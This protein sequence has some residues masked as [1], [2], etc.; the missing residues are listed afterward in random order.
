VTPGR[1]GETI[2][3]GVSDELKAGDWVK[4]RGDCADTLPS[5][6]RMLTGQVVGPAEGGALEV[7][8]GEGRVFPIGRKWLM[9]AEPPEDPGAP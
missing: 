7:R 9:R 4:V 2:G 6:A 5:Y 3:S 1:K 8:F